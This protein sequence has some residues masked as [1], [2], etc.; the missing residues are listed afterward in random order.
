MTT[1]GPVE[2]GLTDQLPDETTSVE[3]NP[4][5]GGRFSVTIRTRMGTTQNV[6]GTFTSVKVSGDGTI[7]YGTD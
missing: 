3:L 1:P 6:N 5:F 7:E 4:V 2:N